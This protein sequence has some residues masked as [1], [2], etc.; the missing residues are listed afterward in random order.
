[1]QL[2][3]NFKK[4]M[5]NEYDL[6]MR[7]VGRIN[8]ILSSILVDYNIFLTDD[9]YMTLL[10]EC[11]M[12]CSTYAGIEHHS[13]KTAPTLAESITGV[14]VTHSKE[15]NWDIYIKPYSYESKK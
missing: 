3:D 7:A 6:S 8:N 15:N 5:N 11:C 14:L 13:E 1:M 2:S 4:E 12:H 9:E 10:E